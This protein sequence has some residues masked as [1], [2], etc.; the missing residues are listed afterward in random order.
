MAKLPVYTNDRSITTGSDFM[1]RVS[2]DAS[3]AVAMNDVAEGL[4]E[5]GATI[6]ARQD[7]Q[8]RFAAEKELLEF[9]RRNT[10]F[11][12]ESSVN[13]MPEDGAGFHDRTVG[14]VQKDMEGVLSRIPESLRQE[15]ELKLMNRT[16]G[17]AEHAARMELSQ[18]GKF[19]GKL[20]N[21]KA[22][23]L[24]KS[25]E[26]GFIPREAAH[27]ELEEFITAGGF[28]PEFAKQIRSGVG[29]VIDSAFLENLRR[30]NPQA[31]FKEMEKYSMTGVVPTATPIQKTIVEQSRIWGVD[32]HLMLTIAQAES[33][34]NPN[35]KASKTIFGVFQLSKAL[36]EKYGIPES[37]KGDI[38]LQSSAMAQELK[39]HQLRLEA[40]GIKPTPASMWGMHFL[41]PAGYVA[42]AQANPDADAYEVYRSVAGTRI[43][44]LAFN[45]SNGALLK[46]GMTAGQVMAGIERNISSK[47]KSVAGLVTVEGVGPGAGAFEV[48]G[49]KL[50]HLDEADVARFYSSVK[51]DLQ[52]AVGEELKLVNKKE[53]IDDGIFDRFDPSDRKDMDEASEE[54]RVAIQ[55]GDPDAI[56]KYTRLAQ[57]GYLPKPA[58]QAAQGLM[59][60]NSAEH[61]ALGYEL[62]AAAH[63]SDNLRALELSGVPAEIKKRVEAYT[64]LK[65]M[66]GS[67][68]IQA[69]N[70]IEL[71]FSPEYQAKVKLDEKAITREKSNIRWATVQRKLGLNPWLSANTSPQS[72]AAQKRVVAFAQERYEHHRRATG[73]QQ[74]AEALTYQ[75]VSKRHGHTQI[76][77]R[78]RF[79]LYPPEAV[80]P[81][82]K[83]KTHSYVARQLTEHVQNHVNRA[84]PEGGKAPQ[85]KPD[86]IELVGNAATGHDV[87][88]GRLPGYDVFYKDGKGEW[89]FVPGTFRADPKETE[90]T[91]PLAAEKG[92]GQPPVD[93][94]ALRKGGKASDPDAPARNWFPGRPLDVRG[95]LGLPRTLERDADS[96]AEQSDGRLSSVVGAVAE[97]FSNP[98]QAAPAGGGGGYPV[99]ATGGRAGRPA[100]A[101]SR[102]AKQTPSEDPSRDDR[103]RQAVARRLKD[104]RDGN[105]PRN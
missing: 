51:T 16:N 31:L 104:I 46:P 36:R 66:T 92:E 40:N 48:M 82:G 91:L 76:L 6:A 3:V 55:Q 32:P 19:I 65:A 22:D 98:A 96:G 28:K 5:I 105:K 20:T 88:A 7:K 71:T 42:M 53:K 52:K 81:T 34:F 35:A 73:S 30:T 2:P 79:M 86:Q 69:M 77:G 99:A 90:A 68:A 45:G 25:V 83:D 102:P 97:A 80:Y 62:L 27:A 72:E 94:G 67:S 60:S 39:S 44:G 12:M 74:V 49:H 29:R 75:D 15:Y 64:A 4:G 37:R 38:L 1:R 33:S 84:V 63:A 26:E 10:N 100:G 11:L 59:A 58:A 9:D 24:A 87:L 47:G 13:D 56:S 61:K 101:Q 70:E 43:A 89:Q 14:A 78:K 54:D 17:Y 103:N 50:E 85:I 18:R 57:D 21:D 93:I 8:S 95:A 23:Y 41:G